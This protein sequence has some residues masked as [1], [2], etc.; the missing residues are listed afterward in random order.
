MYCG[1]GIADNAFGQQSK[2]EWASKLP[3]SGDNSGFEILL[4]CS[5]QVEI[6]KVSE[7]LVAVKEE[8]LR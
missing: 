2:E 3:T 6:L 8:N 4:W 1:R 7:N 5:R